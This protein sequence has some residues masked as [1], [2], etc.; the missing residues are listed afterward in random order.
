[1]ENCND[2]LLPYYK[3]VTVSLSL[4]FAE[5]KVD[6]FFFPVALSHSFPIPF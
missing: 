2:G 6:L 1:M 5:I 4:G 3:D